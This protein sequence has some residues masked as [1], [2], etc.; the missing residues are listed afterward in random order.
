MRMLG[1]AFLAVLT[2]GVVIFLA[3][4]APTDRSKSAYKQSPPILLFLGDSLTDGYTL[5]TSVAYPK[6]IEGRLQSEGLSLAVVNAGRSGDTAE[7]ALKRLQSLLESRSVLDSEVAHFMVA[8]GA[9]DAFHALPITRT[10][11]ALRSILQKVKT[12]FPEATFTVA[13]IVPLRPMTP[14][15]EANFAAMYRKIAAD[16]SATLIPSLLEGVTGNSSL[17][18]RDQIHPNEAG[19]AAIAKI[20]WQALAPKLYGREKLISKHPKES[21]GEAGRYDRANNQ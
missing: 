1:F 17:L 8:L 9:N 10:D 15:F 11:L 4:E 16:F 6:L 19:Q 21:D 13:A 18:M 7:Q 5:G 20:V 2:L 14:E 12:K 3:R